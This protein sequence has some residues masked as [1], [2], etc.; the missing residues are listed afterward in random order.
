MRNGV[1]PALKC[2][3]LENNG[4]W[5]FDCQLIFV[6]LLFLFKRSEVGTPDLNIFSPI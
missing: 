5:K 6:F 3:I 4:D 1:V 2:L